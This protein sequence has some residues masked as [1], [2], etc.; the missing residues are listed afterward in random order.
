M[1]INCGTRVNHALIVTAA[2]G[3][4]THAPCGFRLLGA[5][6][7]RARSVRW[8]L[9]ENGWRRSDPDPWHDLFVDLDPSHRGE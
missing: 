1:P 8:L 2:G 4:A 3:M 5:N 7:T 9:A 6:E